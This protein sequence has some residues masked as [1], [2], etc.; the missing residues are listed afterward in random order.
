M[1]KMNTN[2]A[3]EQSVIIKI[4]MKHI[5]Q[6]IIKKV[7]Y[8]SIIFWFVAWISPSV[9]RN[10]IRTAKVERGDLE[11][12]IT[13]TGL[14]VPEFEQVIS[15]PIDTRILRILKKAGDTLH[16]QEPILLLDLETAML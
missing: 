9:Q 13:A 11:A 3:I 1:I 16:P 2:C 8:A 14:V 4:Q 7:I 12:S 15:S 5:L 10:Q 6:V